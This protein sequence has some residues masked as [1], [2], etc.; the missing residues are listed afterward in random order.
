MVRHVPQRSVRHREPH[1]GPASAQYRRSPPGS[2]YPDRPAARRSDAHATTAAAVATLN[3]SQTT[4]ADFNGDGEADIIACDDNTGNLYIWAGHGQR[5]LR[6]PHPAHH[7]LVTR[8]SPRESWSPLSHA[9]LV[10]VQKD[11]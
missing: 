6:R 5:R 7:R 8:G 11:F 9:R 1:R 2:R 3:Y 4:S 10:D